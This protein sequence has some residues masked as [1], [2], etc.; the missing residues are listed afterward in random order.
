M[1]RDPPSVNTWALATIRT[2]LKRVEALESQVKKVE[3]TTTGFKFNSEACPF[4]PGRHIYFDTFGNIVSYDFGGNFKEWSDDEVLEQCRNL[5][6]AESS[7]DQQ[8]GEVDELDA[9]HVHDLRPDHH[10]GA[11]TPYGKS[12]AENPSAHFSIPDHI[13]VD[14]GVYVSNHI[15]DGKPFGHKRCEV[16]SDF[17][18]EAS[19][20]SSHTDSDG[21]KSPDADE[22]VSKEQLL[23][24]MQSRGMSLDDCDFVQKLFESGVGFGKRRGDQ[25]GE[26]ELAERREEDWQRLLAQIKQILAVGPEHGISSDLMGFLLEAGASEINSLIEHRHPDGFKQYLRGTGT[27]R[28]WFIKYQ[29]Q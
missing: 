11:E 10:A 29:C 13:I 21:E 24:E 26:R 15:W 8:G 17:A 14:M 2:L 23:A 6:Q 20:T 9:G 19:E 1:A 16:V 18:S 28:Q 12:I 7:E 25:A 5:E 22:Q 3:T 4:F 27:Q